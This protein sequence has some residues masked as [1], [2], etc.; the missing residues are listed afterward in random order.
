MLL[1]YNSANVKRLVGENEVLQD[2][3]TKVS[4]VGGAILRNNSMS[5]QSAIIAS[6]YM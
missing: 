2:N 6:Q 5:L 3:I 4:F 1:F